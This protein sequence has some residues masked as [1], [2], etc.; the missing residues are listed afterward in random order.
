[1]PF[2]KRPLALDTSSWAFTKFWTAAIKYDPWGYDSQKVALWCKP[3]CMHNIANSNSDIFIIVICLFNTLYH[4]LL[5]VKVFGPPQPQLLTCP[6]SVELCLP[7]PFAMWWPNMAQA[8]NYGS[9]GMDC[10]FARFNLIGK[11]IRL[12][13]QKKRKVQIILFNLP[14]IKGTQFIFSIYQRCF[15]F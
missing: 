6:K 12:K 8:R 14:N 9:K 2:R 15:S 10:L 5:G 7:Y 3:S 4:S 1:L 11:P 13:N